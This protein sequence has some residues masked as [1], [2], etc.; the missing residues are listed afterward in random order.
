MRR[1]QY[2]HEPNGLPAVVAMTTSLGKSLFH[3]DFFRTPMLST[4]NPAGFK[5]WQHFVVHAPR[6]RLLINFSLA[7]ENALGGRIRQA[8]RVIVIAHGERWHGSIERFNESEL[9]ISADL[10]S[11]VIGES[12]MTVGADGYHVVI[13][14]PHRDISGELH[15]TPVSRPFVVNNQVLG[16]GRLSWLFVP[17]LHADGWV[18]IGSFEHRFENEVAYHDHNWGRFWWG[19]DFGWE[20]GTVLPRDIADPWSL[21][22]MRMTDRR[23]LRYLSQALY[24][25]H[26]DEPA[27]MFRHGAMQV[28]AS[29]TLNRQA[30]CTLPPPMRLLLDGEMPSIPAQIVVD[31]SHG[32][33]TVRAEF[34]PHSYARL[35][36][37]SELALDRSTVLCESSGSARMSGVINGEEID[38]TGTGV[39]EFLYG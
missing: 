21:V 33:D 2:T 19:D 14:L 10:A 26:R 30:D 9:D 7:N 22:F 37:P 38:F 23:R 18:R 35:A 36:Q 17:R 39:F 24:V 1:I 20:W 13:E 31:A 6:C 5:E 25:W 16:A 8:P 32:G 28:R 11:L 27:A 4:A 29:G 15:L 12:R 34:H 3:T